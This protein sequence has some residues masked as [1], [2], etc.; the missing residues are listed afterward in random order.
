[1]SSP[2]VISEDKT[3]WWSNLFF[4]DDICCLTYWNLQFS[5]LENVKNLNIKKNIHHEK[6]SSKFVLLSVGE[7]PLYLNSGSNIFQG[8]NSMKKRWCCSLPGLRTCL[9]EKFFTKSCG[10]ILI[11]QSVAVPVCPS[12]SQCVP[13]LLCLPV[14]VLTWP[15][16]GCRHQRVS[17]SQRAAKIPALH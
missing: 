17:T 13:V 14:R 2:I 3:N 8:N 15:C 9:L 16:W 1:M 10:V 5:L 6:L 11:W 4:Q 12:V 7:F